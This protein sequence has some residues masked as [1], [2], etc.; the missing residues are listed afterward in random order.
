MEI[1]WQSSGLEHHPFTAK[2]EG[3]ILGQ[4]T[5]TPQARWHGQK[6][7]KNKKL[8]KMKSCIF[9]TNRQNFEI[10]KTLRKTSSNNYGLIIN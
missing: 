3:S 10:M 6:I 7:K 8:N 5:K 2:G 4:G 9:L 1:P